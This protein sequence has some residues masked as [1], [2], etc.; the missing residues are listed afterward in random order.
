MRTRKKSSGRIDGVLLAAIALI[1]R[2]EELYDAMQRERL[3]P[4]EQ[5]GI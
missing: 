4:P 1:R 5:E 2:A 3:T